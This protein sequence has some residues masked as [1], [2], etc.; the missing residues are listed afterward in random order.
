L[1]QSTT[2]YAAASGSANYIQNTTSQ[3]TSANFNIDG[4]G[5]AG[6]LQTGSLDAA[7]STALNIGTTKA[8]AINLNQNT[9][10]AADKGLT[11]NYSA[12]N[13]NALTVNNSTGSLFNVDTTNTRVTVGNIGS[14]VGAVAQ[15]KLCVAQGASGTTGSVV[16][17]NTTLA[18]STTAAG[19]YYGQYMNL[20]DTSVSQASS[21]YGMYVDASSTT[22]SAA[23]VISYK[24]KVAASQPGN[25]LQFQNGAS[26]VL[27]ATNSGRLG[28][29]TANPAYLLDVQ[30]GTGI[31]AQFSGR[32]IGANAVSNNEFATL[33]QVNSL[34]AGSGAGAGVT[35]LNALSGA[36]TIQ[37]NAQIAVDATTSPNIK[38]SLQADSIGD[39][40]LAFNTGQN[41]TTASTPQ[42]AG[43]LINTTA[44][45]NNALIDVKMTDASQTG[46]VLQATS[47]GQTAN[48][49]EAY[50][51]DGELGTYIN[52]TA[53]LRVQ[54]SADGVIAA[55]IQQHSATQSAD[56]LQF[57]AYNGNKLS[58]FDATG[59]LGLGTSSPGYMLDVA[60]SVN[61]VSGYVV[62]GT[63]GSGITCTGGDVLSNATIQGGI[64]TGGSC[65]ANGGGV[66]PTLQDVYNNS[67][68]GN[69]VIDSTRGAL[70]IK[71]SAT[72]QPTILNV[73]NNS[74]SQS[75]LSV[76]AA[77]VSMS[78]GTLQVAVG[79][80]VVNGTS[81]TSNTNLNFIGNGNGITVGGKPVA[82]ATTALVQ[83]GNSLSGANNVSNGG[84]V[85]GSNLPSSGV[86]SAADFLNF[87]KAGATVLKVDN[88]GGITSSTTINAVTG[89]K[90]N[91]TAGATTTCSGGQVLSN[92][93]VQGGIVTS[94][95]C[96]TNGGGIAPTLQDAY[97]N[98]TSPASILLGDAKNFVVTAADTATDPS[99]LFNLQCV[100]SCGS[101]GRFAVQNAGTDVFAVNPNGTVVIGSATNGITL[102]ASG[103]T[104]SGTARPG[105]RIPL[106]AEYPNAVLDNGSTG[107]NAGTMTSGYDMSNRMNYYKWT[108]TQSTNQTYDVVTQ[109]PIPDNW[110]AW[111]GNI[112]V[113]AYTS[114]T[115]NGTVKI[116]AIDSNGVVESD[117]NFVSATPAATGAWQT[118]SNCNLS[119]SGN[120]Y[121]A[122]GYITLR[123]RLQSPN[124]GDVRVGNITLYYKANR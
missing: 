90:S 33:G 15:G 21:L 77:G 96:A 20:V 82:S 102:S 84:T 26:T 117:C 76:S 35:S 111:N 114:N 91:G 31:V 62:N 116:Q 40:Q 67:A 24:A 46:L 61:S 93:V 89:F 53:S 45:V 6:A 94:G 92:A 124:A 42:F 4:T 81:F 101:N 9:V 72:S 78:N 105:V 122:G 43:I 73:T 29:G 5:V 63:A 106:M 23:S 28:L 95:T 58:V 2:A 10:L 70:V 123:I 3:Q 68:N 113:S 36:L 69:L 66:A 47:G 98:S 55:K 65:A 75:Y 1:G 51:P 71:D 80:T 110:G 14:C 41:L 8:T 12:G 30:G 88:S 120:T 7:S 107:N 34:I 48:L 27:T 38:L 17:Q 108:T 59:R 50:T 57:T 49:F 100:T 115:T 109:V 19:S 18:V 99:I 13:A 54:A 39:A 56:L 16:A 121:T 25:F 52:N 22:N 119:T 86:G 87:Q 103:I 64:V 112:D 11:V 104:L 44:A 60:G 85:L 79:S 37:G 32:V 97:N 118:T 74:G 83:L